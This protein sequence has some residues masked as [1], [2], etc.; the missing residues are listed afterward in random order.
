VADN[1]NPYWQWLQLDTDQSPDHYT[2]LGLPP[3]ETDPE[4]IES[5]ADKAAARVRSQR[6]GARARE[7]AALLD[8]IAAAKQTL[9]DES[10][11]AAYDEQLRTGSHVG[12]DGENVGGGHDSSVDSS[13]IRRAADNSSVE[14]APTVERVPVNP[15]MLPPG[16]GGADL[17]AT[18][19]EPATATTNETTANES[20]TTPV[21]SDSKRPAEPSPEP[22]SDHE[23]RQLAERLAE[24]TEVPVHLLPPAAA[25]GSLGGPNPSDA[26]WATGSAATNQPSAPVSGPASPA[27]PASAHSDSAEAHWSHVPKTPPPGGS[28]IHGSQP[29]AASQYPPAPAM[30]DHDPQA[31]VAAPMNPGG[32]S[33]PTGWGAADYGQPQTPVAPVAQP[34]SPGT[35][36]MAPVAAPVAEGRLPEGHPQGPA[37]GLAAVRAVSTAGAAAALSGAGE[38]PAVP[39]GPSTAQ[40]ARARRR[41]ST[42]LILG[43]GGA[44]A[45]V[46][47]IILF[48]ALGDR[49]GNDGANAGEN[50]GKQGGQNPANSQAGSPD[51]APA[52]KGADKGNE[53]GG[54]T[55]GNAGDPGANPGGQNNGPGNAANPNNNGGNGGGNPTVGVPG[56]DPANSTPPGGNS[57]PAGSGNG[58]NGGTM[59]GGSGG[60]PA[61]NPGGG[62][63]TANPPTG[64][65]IRPLP[66]GSGDKPAPPDVAG[67]P[68][69]T[70]EEVAS[71]ARSL[72]TARQALGER[73]LALAE[74][75]LE[76]ARRL[77]K[78]PL[79]RQLVDRLARVSQHVQ[80]FWDAVGRGAK[81]V[82]PGAAIKVGSAT[83]SVVK[84]DEKQ[85]TVRVGNITTTYNVRDLPLGL[86]AA[87]ADRALDQGDPSS[88]VLKGA[89]FAVDPLLA[90]SGQAEEHFKQATQAGAAVGDLARFP[91]DSYDLK[92]EAGGASGSQVAQ[93][94]PTG[95]PMPADPVMKNPGGGE[96][97]PASNP[98]GQPKDLKALLTAI[99]AVLGERKLSEVDALVARAEQLAQT[100]QEKKQVAAVRRLAREG[101][102]FW[103]TMA[104]GV[105]KLRGGE[106]LEK[107]DTI[108]SVVEASRNKLVMRIAGK[109]HRFYLNNIPAGLAVLIFEKEA[110]INDPQTRVMEGAFRFVEPEGK[111][112]D[113]RRL[114]QEAADEGADVSELMSLLK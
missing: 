3:L 53:N 78:L 16:M 36:P 55:N 73:D 38:E 104:R 52:D 97:P 77:A 54:Q 80:A 11:K 20:T 4:E 67:G 28:G 114:W 51:G 110:D 49:S 70:A 2:L 25:A 9:L 17:G 32:P 41:T 113:V 75:E 46:L 112:E 8:Q 92:S 68:P 62:E 81:S 66:G 29:A 106:T 63:T 57:E 23:S 95:K 90:D 61:T 88:H 15:N 74:T 37:S 65:A 109:N 82:K 12:I 89:A 59:V 22:L 35:D 48:V 86:A 21:A 1:F 69:P 43:V 47:A 44:L 83:A 72:R 101:V 42:P 26:G 45:A 13:V 108:A 84:A 107:G 33:A 64:G 91:E 5:A 24:T 102:S 58:N 40:Q 31:P 94:D 60:P 96:K 34:V 27:G 30:T 6:P 79:H 19:T 93:N 39:T 105:E 50:T 76:K 87:L 100:P 98:A 14:E 85:L 18:P 111:V 71:L 103:H 10:S 7:W 56:G 99:P